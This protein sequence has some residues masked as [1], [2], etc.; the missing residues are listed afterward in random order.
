M[1]DITCNRKTVGFGTIK[2][3]LE[4]IARPNPEDQWIK[5]EVAHLRIIDDRLWEAAQILK[6]R[7][8]SQTGN[9]RQTRKR[10][11][12]GLVKCGACG[13]SMTIVNRERY[14]CSAKRERGTCDSPAGIS[15]VELEERVL[16]GLKDLLLGNETLIEAFAEEFKAE[17][18]RLNRQRGSARRRLQKEFNK[19]NGAIN[20]CVIIHQ[21]GGRFSQHRP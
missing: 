2:I 20:R 16:S 4:R 6:S 14:S 9:K 13:G 18:E 12:S 7:Y 21:G 1:G 15:A 17:L 8:S 5:T 3:A 11:L 10:L 19:V